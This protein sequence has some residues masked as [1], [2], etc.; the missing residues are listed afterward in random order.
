MVEVRSRKRASESDQP[1]V[2]EATGV[3]KLVILRSMN[4]PF[5]L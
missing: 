5:F 4:V 1:V 3:L 2:G